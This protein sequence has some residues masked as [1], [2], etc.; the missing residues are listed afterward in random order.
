MVLLKDSVLLVVNQSRIENELKLIGK[1]FAEV[2]SWSEYLNKVIIIC[3]SASNKY[4][5]RKI[6]HNV[7]LI[8]IPFDLSIN[9]IKSVYNLGKNY[10]SLLL[11]L[12][13]LTN[14]IKI[15]ILGTE[16][17]IISGPVIFLMS[18]LRKIPYIVWL[19]GNERKALFLKY[20]KTIITK[21]IDKLIFIFEILILK[22]SSF[23]LYYSNEL[24]ESGVNRNLKNGIVTPNFVDLYKFND[25]HSSNIS[26]DNTCIKILFV[27]R[28]SEE[29]GIKVLLKSIKYLK[30]KVENIEFLIVG[31]GY[32]KN[33][34][35]SFIKKH[36]LDNIKLLGTFSHDKMPNVYNSAE[37][38]ILPSYTE[39]SPAS[40]IE[41]MSC[42]CACISTEVGECKN[43]IQNDKNGI[44]IPPGDPRIISKTIMKLIIDKEKIELF[45]INGR[46]TILDYER[47]YQKIHKFVFKH[48]L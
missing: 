25:C 34:I 1:Q 18:K 46:K 11:F 10:F 22:N 4:I 14:I 48:L 16:N 42:G 20:K 47:N 41:A 3:Y 15:N 24:M 23:N 21:L 31:D 2:I 29:K 27:G 17:I 33:W 36:K 37:I 39:G 45:R 40:L 38:F 6:H 8:G 28:L 44:L 13:R 5:Y 12:F 9:P 32:L 30:S 35:E 26:Y 7:Y 43:I 19:V